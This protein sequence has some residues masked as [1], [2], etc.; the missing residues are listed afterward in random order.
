MSWE[1]EAYS[2][3]SEFCMHLYFPLIF[4]LLHFNIPMSSLY[5]HLFFAS[6]FS[7]NIPFHY[8][9]TLSL[10]AGTL[11]LIRTWLSRVWWYNHPPDWTFLLLKL[12]YFVGSW[13]AWSVSAQ[14]FISQFVDSSPFS[15][16]LCT[17]S[18]GPAWNLSLSHSFCNSPACACTV[19][20]SK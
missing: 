16:Q 7:S 11:P 6:A 2:F 19:S 4:S 18:A 14:L 17:D 10:S 8:W 12:K 20:Q 5:Y 13:V 9:Q 15:V 1:A 3:N